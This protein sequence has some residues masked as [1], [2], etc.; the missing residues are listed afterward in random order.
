MRRIFI[1]II[2]LILLSGCAT[3]QRKYSVENNIF[4]SSYPHMIL[5][6]DPSLK[7]VGRDTND[8]IG[9]YSGLTIRSMP[10][11]FTTFVFKDTT[12]DKLLLILYI[13]LKEE[14]A[15][16]L[17]SPSLYNK[18]TD[19]V[20][21]WGKKQIGNRYWRYV[22]TAR[23]I[24]KFNIF[25][26]KLSDSLHNHYIV[27]TIGR[28]VTDNTQMIIAYAESIEST[29]FTYE[30]WNKYRLL[31]KQREFLNGFVNRALNSV[32]IVK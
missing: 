32:E 10:I 24:R 4:T 3:I 27:G 5:K 7:Y 15:Y 2:I 20:L 18:N 11:E 30:E 29:G 25:G 17:G 26:N 22:I 8:K 23:D 6:I 1:S 12:S 21:K 9:E 14:G 28:T 16:W 13:R 31:D 19:I